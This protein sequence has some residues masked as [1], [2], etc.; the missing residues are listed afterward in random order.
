MKAYLCVIEWEEIGLK[1][2]FAN[3]GGEDPCAPDT[4]LAATIEIDGAH[5]R[6]LA[7]AQ[8]AAPWHARERHQ[9]ALRRRAQ[10]R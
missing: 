9:E 8:R 7:H 1:V 3:L 4:G 5:Q 10:D 2:N 6:P